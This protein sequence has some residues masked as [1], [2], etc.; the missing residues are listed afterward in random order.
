MHACV[1]GRARQELNIRSKSVKLP[2]QISG[3]FFFSYVAWVEYLLSPVGSPDSPF[4]YLL[5]SVG[6]F[7]IKDR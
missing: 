7:Q 5:M 4:Y 3:V 2:V 6:V 1:C